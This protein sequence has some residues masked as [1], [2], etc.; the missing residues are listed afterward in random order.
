LLT[1]SFLMEEEDDGLRCCT[2][3]IEVIDDHEKNVADNE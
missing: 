2:H 3:I 1:V